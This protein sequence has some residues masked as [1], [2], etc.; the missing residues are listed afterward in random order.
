VAAEIKKELG[1]ASALAP[2]EGGI[3]EVRLDGRLVFTNESTGGVPSPESV[4]EALK[5][6]GV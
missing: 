5:E 2:G 1:L 3:F 4:I 6:A